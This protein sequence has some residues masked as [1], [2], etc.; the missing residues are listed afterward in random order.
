MAAS[1]RPAQTSPADIWYRRALIAVALIPVFFI[2]GFAVAQGLYSLM[3]YLPE[4]AC[5]PLWVDLV[6]TIPTVAVWLVPC[7][8]AVLYGRRVNSVGDRRGL[9][10]LCIGALAGLGLLVLSI[11]TIISSHL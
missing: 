2:L 7:A 6:A 11:V 9:V 10:P 3:G 8:A 4:E 1:Q 5:I